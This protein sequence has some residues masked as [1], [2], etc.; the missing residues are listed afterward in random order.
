MAHRAHRLRPRFVRHAPPPATPRALRSFALTVGA[1]FLALGALL[2]LRGR[3]AAPVPLALG[4]LLIAAGI[5]APSRLGPLHRAW[6][7]L[8][9]AISSVTTPLMMGIIY[10]LILTPLGVAMRLAG[11]RTLRRPRAAASF[12]VDRPPG[13]RRSDLRRQF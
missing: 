4:A 7:A 2:L 9:L 5:A 10:F 13:E 3:V 6:M 8:A 11:R 1:A 12:W